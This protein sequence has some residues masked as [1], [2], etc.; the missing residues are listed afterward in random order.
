[1]LHQQQRRGREEGRGEK[2]RREGEKKKKKGEGRRFD[3]SVFRVPP[4]PRFGPGCSRAL[5]YWVFA[6]KREM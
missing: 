2:E 6:K 4:M 3:S 5:A 1:M